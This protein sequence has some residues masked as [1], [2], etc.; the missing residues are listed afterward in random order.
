MNSS[1]SKIFGIGLSKTGTTSLARALEILGYKTKDY[2]GVSRYSA[3]DLSS[4]KLDE[5]DSNDAFTDTPIPSFY[6]ELDVKY[7]GSLFMDL[8]GCTV[9]DEQNFRNGYENFVSG[10][11][12]YFKDRPQDLLVM[13]VA[14]EDGW[15]KLSPF[16]GKSIP[17]VTFPK[18]NVTQIRWININDVID[19]M[20]LAGKETLAA[21]EIIQ[22]NLNGQGK[23]RT[24]QSGAGR[25]ILD[26]ASYV[27][28]GGDAG[29]QRAARKKTYKIITKRLRELNPRIPVISPEFSEVLYSQRSGWNH[30]WLVDPLDSDEGLL[31]PGGTFT[32][33][34][35]LIEDRKPNLGIIYAP[36]LD[37][38]YYATVGNKA[39]KIDRAGYQKRIEAHNN[40]D[41]KL[42]ISSDRSRLP[43]EARRNKS[44][45]TMSKALAICLAA[46]GK[47]HIAHLLA[48]TMEWQTAG[49]HAVLHA[50]GMKIISRTTKEELTYNKE[51]FRNGPIIIE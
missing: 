24:R 6:R 16:L 47:S 36:S 13:D 28:R 41:R 26:K 44:P 3:G 15:G 33:N 39:F 7:P 8:Y 25:S 48:D 29:I 31:D 4:I 35:A 17:D 49:A 5:I 40:P 45:A 37:T 11:L 20:R 32:V 50:S 12:Q 18:A 1:Q 2:L 30:F 43:S 46:E 23:Q 21:Y 27:L 14:A 10:V 42:S 9:F 19:V 38:V 22:A 51:S 34:I